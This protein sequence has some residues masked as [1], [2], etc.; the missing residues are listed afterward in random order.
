MA[1]AFNQGRQNGG[2]TPSSGGSTGSAAP[3]TGAKIPVVKATAFDPLGDGSEND[4]EVGN[5]IDS[6]P[7][8]GWQTSTYYNNPALGGLKAGVGVLLDLGSDKS[9]ASVAIH[10]KG[11]PT[12][13]EVY[14]ASSG[15]TQPPDALD[16]LTK[17]GADTGRPRDHHRPRRRGHPHALPADLVDQAAASARGV[18]R[19]DHRRHG[20]LVTVPRRRRAGRS[21]AFSRPT[22]RV[23]PT[24][25]GCSSPGTATGCGPWPCAR[26][27]NR[28]EAADALQDAMISA[29][30]R[31]DS[32]RGDAAVT[33][34]L[35]RIVVNAC[36]DRLR[37]RQVRAADPL[38]DDLEEHAA[39]GDVL[40]L[41]HGR[42]PRSTR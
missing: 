23:T 5:V 37:R 15:V 25:S 28:E 4:A 27:V 34:W 10:F 3:N 1:I 30:R 26:P 35:H 20:P 9:P 41:G 39:R 21:R 19:R 31:A 11:H 16:Q 12:D 8:S 14:A 22:S 40:R 36:L 7:A 13:V 38:P 29:F 6:D 32:F 2:G 33:T 18:P 17:V 42:R 24:P